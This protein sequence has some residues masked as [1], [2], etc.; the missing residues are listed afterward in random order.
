MLMFGGIE[1]A[2]R[3]DRTL[4]IFPATFLQGRSTGRTIVKTNI[5]IVAAGALL[6]ATATSAGAELTVEGWLD[7]YDGKSRLPASVAQIV[8]SSY[9]LGLA[10]GVIS[11]KIM[12]CPTEYIPKAEVIAKKV[13]EVLRLERETRG[14]SVTAAVLIALSLDGCTEGPRASKGTR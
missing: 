12:S 3:Q 13:A 14:I 7:F 11:T 5:V 9:A 4:T 10:D 6:L 8:A 1:P 2:A